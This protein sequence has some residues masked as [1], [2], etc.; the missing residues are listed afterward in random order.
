M[1]L[2]RILTDKAPK[3]I[4]PY[5]QGVAVDGKVLY[6]AGQIAIDPATGG[7]V[8]GDIK[9]QTRQVLKNL[10]EILRAGG[11]SMK[12]VVKTTVFMKDMNEFASMNEVY[13]EFF[14]ES[15]PARSTVEVRRLPKDVRVEIEAVALIGE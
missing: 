11:A 8:E 3:P 7:I 13:S 4:G 10:D 6:T 12:S 9:V 2:K 1:A 14:A 5:S 15:A